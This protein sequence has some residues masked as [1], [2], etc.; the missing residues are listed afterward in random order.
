MRRKLALIFALAVLFAAIL[1]LKPWQMGNEGEPRFFDRLPDADLIGKANVLDLSSTMSSA[2]YHYKVPF[3]EFLTREFLLQQ[4]KGLGIELQKPAYFFANETDW[5]VNDFGIM[6]LIKDSTLMRPGLERLNKLIHLADTTVYNQKVY[7]HL[8]SRTYLAYGSDWLLVYS[9]DNFKRTFHD[10]LF[11]KRNEIPPTWR[12]FLNK[13][14]T[15]QSAVIARLAT[16][17]LIDYGVSWVD[18]RMIN[19]S[20]SITISGSIQQFDTIGIYPKTSGPSFESQEFTRSLASIHLDV[21]RLRQNP[22]DPISRVLKDLGA[23]ISFPVNDFLNAWSGDLAMRQGGLQSFQERYIE[24]ELDEDFNI[25]EVEKFKTV[26]VPGYSIYLSMNPNYNAFI[27]RLLNKG[28]L[29]RSENR[30][31]MLFSPPMQLKKQKS[32]LAFY[33]ANYYQQPVTS[34]ENFVQFTLARTPVTFYL[35]SVQTK[36]YFCRLKLPL[37]KFVEESIPTDVP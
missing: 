33:T 11:A 7:Q 24:S 10:V 14:K 26:K 36:T 20:T 3:R 2:T 5:K 37:D 6:F 35:D 12:N 8:E 27:D 17:D 29:T 22:N 15:D 23:K 31:R 21:S 18:M 25:T 1:I 32:S 9:G 28:I 34:K 16:K 19:D 4:A 30:Y 13:T